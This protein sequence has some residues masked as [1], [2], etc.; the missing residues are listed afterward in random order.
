MNLWHWF[1]GV[2]RPA[3]RRNPVR[4]NLDAFIDARG[5]VHPIRY[6][7]GYDPAAAGEKPY[8]DVQAFDVLGKEMRHTQRKEDVRREREAVRMGV[9]ELERMRGD[10]KADLAEVRE[11]RQAA[12]H[13]K[14]H[15]PS[16]AVG[17]TD[18]EL[19][20][21]AATE[22][23]GKSAYQQD[24]D[25]GL[26]SRDTKEFRDLTKR[27]SAKQQLDAQAEK[28]KAELATVDEQL[29]MARRSAKRNPRRKGIQ[30]SL[31]GDAGPLRPLFGGGGAKPKKRRKA[32]GAGDSI[33]AFQP[34]L[35]GGA[36]IRR[37]GFDELDRPSSLKQARREMLD[38]GSPT[39]FDWFLGR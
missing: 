7:E 17:W 33:D 12:S 1:F 37:P 8:T 15:R 23:R 31:F 22:G 16:W 24:W 38:S 34:D 9:R 29:R 25:A 21:Y 14:I 26:F 28:L 3:R 2:K 18:E 30:A 13:Q 19:S 35:F 32:R 36:G 27:G 39:L 11:A 6:S 20:Q 5:V 10:I 4:R